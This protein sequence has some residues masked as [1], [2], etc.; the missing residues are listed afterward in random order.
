M[1]SKIVLAMFIISLGIS[2]FAHATPA[3]AATQTVSPGLT[4]TSDN[5]RLNS[6]PATTAT[7]NGYNIQN[8]TESSTGVTSSDSG[9]NQIYTWRLNDISTLVCSQAHLTSLH[10]VANVATPTEGNP[11][12]AALAV[13]RVDGADTY[14]LGNYSIASGVD[15]APQTGLFTPPGGAGISGVVRGT[16]PEFG[17]NI[18]GNI[19]A[20]WDISALSP[21][22]S[23]G[24]LVQQ[25]SEDGTTDLQTSIT[26]LE[27]TYDDSACVVD[28]TVTKTL[29]N[30]S[31]VVP[32]GTATFEIALGNNGTETITINA[33]EGIFSDISSPSLTYQRVDSTDI[34]DFGCQT[35]GTVQ[36]MVNND[37]SQVAAYRN[38]LNY[39]VTMCASTASITLNPGQTKKLYM[40]FS[41]ASNATN[42]SNVAVFIP[43]PV[44]NVYDQGLNE[45]ANLV[46]TVQT[47]DKDIFD[48]LLSG[49]GSSNNISL[50]SYDLTSSAATELAAS[51]SGGLLLINAL[52]VV[53]LVVSAVAIGRRERYSV[54]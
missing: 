19:D 24:I 49:Q 54:H 17:G 37:Q 12:L 48:T 34:N 25:D 31:S 39:N 42:I 53:G 22:D 15:Y 50:V 43:S 51:G 29:Q 3:R 32:G 7:F 18:A 41:V 28:G 47:G 16:A 38:H 6:D 45:L 27:V 35:L 10:V 4:S 46:N 52:G 33:S 30:P 40:T 8:G 11:D 13:Y 20:T 44:F 2:L 9:L 14:N 21:A 26:T 23:L 1:K 36:Q 5:P